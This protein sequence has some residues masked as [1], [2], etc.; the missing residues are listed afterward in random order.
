MR[1]C[2]FTPAPLR[3]PGARRGATHALLESRRC[4]G[5]RKPHRG[6]PA[7]ARGRVQ[8]GIEGAVAGGQQPRRVEGDAAAGQ[9]AGVAGGVQGWAAGVCLWLLLWF[10][11]CLQAAAV[12]NRHA[13]V[14]CAPPPHLAS[15]GGR[16]ASSA[17]SAG[18]CGSGASGPSAASHTI[19]DQTMAGTNTKWMA[20][21]AKGGLRAWLPPRQRRV[22]RGC[23]MY[24]SVR[25]F[26]HTVCLTLVPWVAVIGPVKH[27]LVHLG[28]G[29]RACPVS[30][31]GLACALMKRGLRSGGCA[32]V[33]QWSLL[34]SGARCN[35]CP[36]PHRHRTRLNVR[37]A[38]GPARVTGRK[39]RLLAV[40]GSRR[41]AA[42]VRV[43]SLAWRRCSTALR[44]E[45]SRGAYAGTLA[46]LYKGELET[47]Y[48]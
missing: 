18:A 2:R 6:R 22:R 40:C 36:A 31:S 39:R 4:Q 42:T 13:R 7:E 9:R 37:P 45:R 30:G 10:A 35:R 21:E 3:R 29:G 17:A 15:H 43:G 14:S 32:F 44:V 20:A 16:W 47:P 19:A 1:A 11:A 46:M 8:G 38:I 33:L 24:G 25:V 23:A 28:R 5:Q 48:I 41:S 34:R 12:A 26:T 27:K